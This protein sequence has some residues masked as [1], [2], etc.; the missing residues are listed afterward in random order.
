[1]EEE[2]EVEMELRDIMVMEVVE[3]VVFE[4]HGNIVEFQLHQEEEVQ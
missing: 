4:H 2:E 1:M 3:Q